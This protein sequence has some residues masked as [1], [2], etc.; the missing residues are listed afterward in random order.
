MQRPGLADAERVA[1]AFG[2]GQPVEPVS[3]G[4]INDSYRIAA[5]DGLLLLQWINPE[6]FPDP[7]AVADNVACVL[8]HLARHD[9]DGGWPAV[10]VACAGGHKVHD[11]SG[12]WRALTFLPD[13]VRIDRPND[14]A[15]ARVGA[16]GFARFV[17]ALRDLDPAQLEPV[18]PGFHDLERRLA[19]LDAAVAQASP[20]RLGDVGRCLEAAAGLRERFGA[21]P[22]PAPLRII[23]GD[24]KF[25]NL[26]FTADRGRALAVDYD[27][28]M[29]GALAWDF[30]DLLRSAASSGVED[31]P[32]GGTLREPI[33]AAAARGYLA[34]LGADLGEAERAALPAA[35]AQMA[36]MLG[37][38]F[39]TDFLEGDR[40][41]RVTRRQ[42]NLDRAQHQLA[43]AD[44]LLIR[45]GLIAEL[46]H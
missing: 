30:G 13:R 45:Q 11:A 22:V 32:E 10:A 33:L 23:H 5:G 14:P 40:Y 46:L 34:V 36:F 16:A 15:E 3:G 37:V 28:V 27:T 31:D 41:F 9:P 20:T 24:T 12:V 4:H 8:D 39:L 19:A 1:A 43:L 17:R 21:D 44:A 2:A 18:L 38:R 29:A 25:S 35:P 26:L 7:D 42:Q 6:V